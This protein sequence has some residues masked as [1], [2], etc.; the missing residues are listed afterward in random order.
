VGNGILSIKEC[1]SFSL[2][3]FKKEEIP[4]DLLQL[5]DNLERFR[6]N[7]K[8]GRTEKGDGGILN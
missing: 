1:L 4:N 7:R 8:R 6:A 3:E 5:I 2:Y